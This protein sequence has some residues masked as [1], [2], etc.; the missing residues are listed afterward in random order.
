MTAIADQYDVVVVGG[1]AAGLSAALTLGRSRR[2]VL[3]VDAGEPRNARA[4]GVHNYLGQE[5]T[6]PAELAEIGRAE[7]RQYGGLTTDGRVV[8]AWLV[9]PAT[10]GT[11]DGIAFRVDLE[12]G[13]SVVA[14]RL[15]VASGA[16]D[17]LP[18]VPGLAE[19]WG[20]GVVHCPYCH[21]WE[22]R[23]RAIGVLLTSAMQVHQVHMFRQ[24]SE[25]V[26]VFVTDPAL[27]D[28]E[29]RVR[30][31]ARGIQVIDG[32]VVSVIGCGSGPERRLAGVQ[33][34]DGSVV[35][36]EALAATSSVEAQV[37]FLAGLGLHAEDQVVNGMRFGSVLAVG[38]TG[39]T[40]VPG[41]YAAGNVT[42]AATIVVAASAAGAWVGAAVNGDL[43][44]ADVETALAGTLAG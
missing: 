8:A 2:S 15:V 6:S 43:V 37:D 41:V 3:V 36:V 20:T 31:R 42:N 1:S 11:H 17:V 18:D 33:L 16:V 30:M 5:G 35:A 28:E 23:D 7:V 9:D 40:T 21:G 39:A 22:V 4:A 13:R 19:F 25:D 32:P 10:A 24:L 27:V 26:T 44:L 14:R 38:P 34:G 29:A 12:D